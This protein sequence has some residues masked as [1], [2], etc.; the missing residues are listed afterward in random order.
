M[1]AVPPTRRLAR[2][3]R[4]SSV[5]AAARLLRE[6]DKDERQ[7]GVTQLARRIG[8]SK[9]AAHRIIWTLVDEGLLEKDEE[10]GLFR[11][12]ITMWSLGTSA[13]TVQR[14]RE[15]A[16]IPLDK[17]RRFTSGTMQIGLLED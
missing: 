11:L 1:T 4:L 9:S 13:E 3:Q 8:I 17:L 10:T 2:S 12:T 14:L 7:L 16:T 6:F 5:A 15:S